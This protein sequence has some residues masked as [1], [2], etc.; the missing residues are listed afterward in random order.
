MN[1]SE[2]A[3]LIQVAPVMFDV[4]DEIYR[5]IDKHTWKNTPL[6]SENDLRDSYIILAEEVGEVARALTR[7]EGSM[8]NLEEELIQVAAMA[9]A[10]VVGIRGR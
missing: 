6:N 5:A 9:S 8:R 4:I 10:M 2:E 1:N 7:D 3:S